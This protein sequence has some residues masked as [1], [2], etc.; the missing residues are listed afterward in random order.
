V[1]FLQTLPTFRF[2]YYSNRFKLVH[3]ETPILSW[4]WIYL[5]S[6]M[7]HSPGLQCQ[8][9][10]SAKVRNDTGNCCQTREECSSN[11]QIRIL[12]FQDIDFKGE[13]NARREKPA[14]VQGTVNGVNPL[15]RV[16]L[17]MKPDARIATISELRRSNQWRF[18]FFAHW[19][20]T[21]PSI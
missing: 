17:H 5:S 21:T 15:D 18:A 12:V 13:D 7:E 2:A 3:H 11:K 6:N 8:T 9:V 14:Q 20:N 1:A 4:N 10:L 16:I 19:L